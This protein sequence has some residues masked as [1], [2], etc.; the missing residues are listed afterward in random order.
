MT[1]II[2]FTRAAPKVMSP[3]GPQSQR[4]MVVA[5]QQRLNP[6]NNI[7]LAFVTVQQ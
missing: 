4:Q 3:V 2:Y 7:S 1:F 5:W 6:S